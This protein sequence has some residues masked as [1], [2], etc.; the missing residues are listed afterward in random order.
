MTILQGIGGCTCKY[1]ELKFLWPHISMIY[2]YFNGGCF[3]YFEVTRALKFQATN[4]YYVY[5]KTRHTR[6]YSNTSSEIDPS[7]ITEYKHVSRISA[8]GI[9]RFAQIQNQQHAQALLLCH[10]K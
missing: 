4:F 2:I 6:K 3:V 1:E 9:F 10:G 5:Q 7:A 8:G